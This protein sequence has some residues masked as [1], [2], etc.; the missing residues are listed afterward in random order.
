M[1]PMGRA[2]SQHWHKEAASKA[3]YG[4]NAVVLRVAL[5]VRDMDDR[6]I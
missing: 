5:N 4:G 3:D 1:A 6:A 2:L